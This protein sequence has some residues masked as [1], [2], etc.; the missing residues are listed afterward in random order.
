MA[1]AVKAETINFDEEDVQERL[2]EMTKGR[3]PGRCIGGVGC[4]AHTSGS[5][6]SVVDKAKAAVFL[7]TDH[8]HVIRQAIMCCR[9]QGTGRWR[10]QS[11]VKTVKWGVGRVDGRTLNA[12]RFNGAWGAMIMIRIKTRSGNG[13]E[14]PTLFWCS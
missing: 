7:A 11:G 12:E 10:H 4:E 9:K 3:G 13:R 8:A 14:R 6:D 2:M 5:F 1:R